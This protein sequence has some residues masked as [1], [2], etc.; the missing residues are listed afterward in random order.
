[1]ARE[2]RAAA[3]LC[4]AARLYSRVANRYVPVARLDRIRRKE[5]E[6]GACAQQDARRD[7]C[8]NEPRGF[9]P[10][11]R[12]RANENGKAQ[13]HENGDCATDGRY[14]SHSIKSGELELVHD[15]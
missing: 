4:W 12:D 10:N 2:G 7:G 11:H 8:K 14:P 3:S 5:N 6:E 9:A 1:M 13:A 15:R